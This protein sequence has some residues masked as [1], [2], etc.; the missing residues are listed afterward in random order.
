MAIQNE[1][2]REY[3]NYLADRNFGKSE[4][5]KFG[6]AD[7]GSDL[8]IETPSGN[9]LAL[10]VEKNEDSYRYSV[11]YGTSVMDK[12][13]GSGPAIYDNGSKALERFHD[14]LKSMVDNSELA[15]RGALSGM[16]MDAKRHA[17]AKR[18]QVFNYDRP[19]NIF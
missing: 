11:I 14:T 1:K 4:G 19:L 17:D 15:S 16:L 5:V 12:P 13:D 6:Y 2:I 10:R 3:F 8:V 18:D 9:S 7:N